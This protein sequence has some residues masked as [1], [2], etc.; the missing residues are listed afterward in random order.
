MTEQQT[1]GRLIVFEG[2]HNVGKSILAAHLTNR[3]RV[4]G[5]RCQ[6]PVFPGNHPGSIGH[7]VYELHRK[8]AVREGTHSLVVTLQKQLFSRGRPCRGMGSNRFYQS[9]DSWEGGI[10]LAVA[11]QGSHAPFP[12]DRSLNPRSLSRLAPAKPTV[13]YDTFWRFAAERQE[14]FFRRLGGSSPPWTKD[15]IL[16]R[17]KF[18][19]A[20]RASDRV[21]QYLIRNVIYQ[22]R[23]AQKRCSSAFSSSR[24]LTELRHGN[25]SRLPSGR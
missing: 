14:V 16:D 4:A 20:Y 7:R 22:A 15:P 25:C 17:F 2:P 8:L 6:Q 10:S 3:L 9:V 1:P 11:Q 13:V 12:G 18:T 24:F 5:V 23:N 19:N 21:S